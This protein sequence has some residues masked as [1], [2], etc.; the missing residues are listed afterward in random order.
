[1]SLG[2]L[3]YFP[4]DLVE[5]FQSRFCWHMHNTI[6]P[7]F[8]VPSRFRWVIS[9]FFLT[10]FLRSCWVILFFLLALL[11]SLLL[12]HFHPICW[13]ISILFADIFT[14]ARVG[15][16]ASASHPPAVVRSRAA[17]AAG[18]GRPRI[19]PRWVLE[20]FL[21]LHYGTQTPGYRNMRRLC[22]AIVCWWGGVLRCQAIVSIGS[23]LVRFDSNLRYRLN[24]SD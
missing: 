2:A 19:F 12:S 18:G 9:F 1:M 20:I 24:G 15:G 3:A 4:W 21:V 13:H 14:Q 11:L 8:C 7:M 17:S 22:S 5:T 6:L 16:E 23:A 10:H